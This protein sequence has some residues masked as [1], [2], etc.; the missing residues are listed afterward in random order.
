MWIEY[1]S[2]D[3]LYMRDN[4]LYVAQRMYQIGILKNE[5]SAFL[6]KVSPLPMN[7]NSLFVNVEG[8]T[9]GYIKAAIVAEDS[10]VNQTEIDANPYDTLARLELKAYADD[11]QSIYDDIIYCQGVCFPE[12]PLDGSTASTWS[13]DTTKFQAA[14]D[15]CISQS[16]VFC[17]LLTLIIIGVVSTVSSFLPRLPASDS[18]DSE[19]D[20]E[21]NDT[22]QTK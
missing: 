9:T 18:T 12:F 22:I 7:M 6:Y 5:P 16:R 13:M 11:V 19:E 10:K 21:C 1:V 20:D 14:K 3:A 8:W 4:A 15:A 17:I 2:P